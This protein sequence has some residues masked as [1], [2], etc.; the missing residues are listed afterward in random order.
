VTAVD[1]ACEESIR[2]HLHRAFP[3]DGFI[4]EEFGTTGDGAEAVWTID[5]IDGTRNFTRGIPFWGCLIAR[6][7]RGRLTHG[8]MHLPALGETLWAVRGGGAFLNGRRLRVSRI[9]DLRRSY[10]LY[11]GLSYFVRDRAARR[12]ERIAAECASTRCFGDCWSYSFV[13]RGQVEAMLEKDL[14]PW[15]NAP[16]NIIVREAGGRCTDW[17][18]RDDW[19]ADS[20]LATNGLVHSRL[21]K[22]L[23]R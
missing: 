8:V 5:P 12:L 17:K 19:R 6:A 13:A 4:G 3:G 1:R 2:K 14:K 20:L 22:L 18:G 9:R 15:D 16:V 7:F 23:R 11:G 10:I 21:L